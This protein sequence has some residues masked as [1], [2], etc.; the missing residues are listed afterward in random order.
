ME[1]KLKANTIRDERENA[2]G[3]A[4]RGRSPLCANSA[5]FGR[6]E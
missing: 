6:C 5:T 2:H 1:V 4:G 3:A